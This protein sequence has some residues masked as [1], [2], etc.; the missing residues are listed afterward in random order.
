M[1]LFVGVVALKN[2]SN[3]MLQIEQRIGS[4][5]ETLNL[6]E[7]SSDEVVVEELSGDVMKQEESEQYVGQQNVELIG[8]E[9]PQEQELPVTEDENVSESETDSALKETVEE[10][11]EEVVAPV[12]ENYTVQAGDTLAKISRDFYG[13]DEKVSEICMLNEITDGDYIQ[14]GEIIL[15]P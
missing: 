15:L 7:A 3:E 4:R 8:E 14:A 6:Q 9:I 12:Y 5:L 2:Q 1:V 11:V 13:T 10:P